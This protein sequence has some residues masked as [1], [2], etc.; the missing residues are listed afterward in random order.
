MSVRRLA[1][2]AVAAACSAAE[3]TSPASDPFTGA[4]SL[5]SVNKISIPGTVATTPATGGST[6]IRSGSVVFLDAGHL[7]FSQASEARE[8]GTSPAVAFTRVDTF[9]LGRLPTQAFVLHGVIPNDTVAV[10]T[11][12]ASGRLAWDFRG[13]GGFGTY[14]FT[15]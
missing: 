11:V 15:R 9:A 6:V 7:V 13:T 3:V 2:L 8:T 10:I 5:A 14:L 4:Y 1:L 12:P